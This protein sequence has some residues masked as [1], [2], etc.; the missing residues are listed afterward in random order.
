MGIPVTFNIVLFPFKEQRFNLKTA[1][2]K[3][4]SYGIGFFYFPN[5]CSRCLDN[6]FTGVI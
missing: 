3:A 4:D 5:S 1:D 2:Q 6:S